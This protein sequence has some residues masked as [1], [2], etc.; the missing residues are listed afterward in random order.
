MKTETTI[1][2]TLITQVKEKTSNE[3]SDDHCLRPSGKKDG[4]VMGTKTKVPISSLKGADGKKKQN[5][6]LCSVAH[7]NHIARDTK[8]M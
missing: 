7:C 1:K 6:K 4:V 8:K 2:K 3:S 5:R